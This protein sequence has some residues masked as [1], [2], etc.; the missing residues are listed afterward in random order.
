M[1]RK[2]EI[3]TMS[4]EIVVGAIK[5]SFVKLN[6]LKMYKNPVMF[7]VEVGMFITLLATIFPTYFGSTY[8]E[9]GYNA[10]IT[11]ILFVTV[12]FANFAEALAEGR[13]KA[14]ADT[15]KK[16]KKR[17]WQNSLKVMEA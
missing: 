17:L 1:K 10:L 4:K 6:P 15:L 11:F 9:V 16:T 8:D 13:G 7:V 14:Q 2:R 5:N 12:L 3:K